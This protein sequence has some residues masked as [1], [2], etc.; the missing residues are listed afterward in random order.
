VKGLDAVYIGPSDLSISLGY[1]PG[2]DKPDEW[3]MT[4]LKPLFPG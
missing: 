1:A 2:G 4:A 3:M